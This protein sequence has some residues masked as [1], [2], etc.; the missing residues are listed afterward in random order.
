MDYQIFDLMRTRYGLCGSWTVWNESPWSPDSIRAPQLKLDSVVRT[1]GEVR[2]QQQ[3]DTELP[4]LRTDLVLVALNFAERA[5]GITAVTDRLSF[6]SFHE[7]CGRTS[8]RRLR[9][10]CKGNGLEGAY[11][12]DL[13]KMRNGTL[14]P[15]R[16]SKSMPINTLLRDPRFVR[17]QVDGLCE[18]LQT[19][20]SR[21]PLIVGL[22][23]QVYKALYAPASLDKLR[24]TC[25]NG[26]Q[27]ARI[28]HYSSMTGMTLPTY[29]SRVGQELA[30]FRDY[31]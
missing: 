25:G 11:I 31:L 19:L 22:G 5:A 23:A 2:S 7:E 9:E 29:I 24:E 14:A 10:A 26:T 4:S 3:L 16:S 13:V 28:T 15:F 6:A 27:V 8:D 12:T 21:N 20:G 30:D 18:E 17:E 1:F